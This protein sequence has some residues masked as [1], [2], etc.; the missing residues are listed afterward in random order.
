MDSTYGS[1]Y[2][3]QAAKKANAL[4]SIKAM[5]LVDMIG[6]KNL[7]LRRESAS[8]T[9]LK[10]VIW[11]TAKKLGHGAIFMDEETVVEDDHLEFLPPAC[12][13]STSSTS[14]TRSGTTTRPAATT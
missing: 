11:G 2:Y 9:W 1:R 13:P 6:D 3:V 10:D 8:T 5:I 7:T 12:R 14:T 4:T